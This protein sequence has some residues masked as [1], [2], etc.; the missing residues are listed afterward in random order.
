MILSFKACSSLKHVLGRKEITSLCSHWKT[1]PHL[2]VAG[3]VRPGPNTPSSQTRP[4][5]TAPTRKGQIWQAGV[6]GAVGGGGVPSPAQHRDWPSEHHISSQRSQRVAVSTSKGRVG[7]LAAKLR[8]RARH[9]S[10]SS[11]ASTSPSVQGGQLVSPSYFEI[12]Q[13]PQCSPALRGFPSLL[14]HF[15]LRQEKRRP[16]RPRMRGQCARKRRTAGSN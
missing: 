10:L 8:N 12:G 9:T 11:Q 14:E 3:K 5:T 13:W 1:C 4:K 2:A 15:F 6:G 16:Q 7:L